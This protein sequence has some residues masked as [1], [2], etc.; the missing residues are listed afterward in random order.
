MRLVALPAA[1]AAGALLLAVFATLRRAW[2]AAPRVEPAGLPVA[3]LAA[4]AWPVVL[5]QASG[6]T[7]CLGIAGDPLALLE[8][9]PCPRAQRLLLWPLTALLGEAVASESLE[10]AGL[11]VALLLVY[12]LARGASSSRTAAL[13]AQGALALLTVVVLGPAAGDA[14]ALAFELLFLAHLL[15]RYAHLTGAR[16]AAATTAYALAAQLGGSSASLDVAVLVGVFSLAELLWG[17]RGSARR[18]LASWAVA[19]A[20]VVLAGATPWHRLAW[21]ERPLEGAAIASL[22]AF[23]LLALIGLVATPGTPPH[24][25]RLL[26]AG[27]VA[28]ALRLSTGAPLSLLGPLATLAALG[29]EQAARGAKAPAAA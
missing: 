12:V 26:G 4:F 28:G 7:G 2:P 13:A 21:S 29:L 15:R 3:L 24:R 18:L 6:P 11:G 17:A 19:T 10:A 23:G 27:V 14:V 16:D 8:A 5:G 25:R 22:A 20:V 1:V 9:S